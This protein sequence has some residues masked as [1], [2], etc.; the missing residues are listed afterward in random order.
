MRYHLRFARPIVGSFTS[1][2]ALFLFRW[3][4]RHSS[5]SENYISNAPFL[6][7]GPDFIQS[8]ALRR[9]VEAGSSLYDSPS[10]ICTG[11]NVLEPTAFPHVRVYGL[12]VKTLERYDKRHPTQVSPLHTSVC[13]TTTAAGLSNHQYQRRHCTTTIKPRCLCSARFG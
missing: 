5:L 10:M 3:L 2:P 7:W 13:I 1:L 12:E 6:A 9:Y 8:S 4:M 11:I